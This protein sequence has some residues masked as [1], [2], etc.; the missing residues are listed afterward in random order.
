M[1][2][3]RSEPTVRDFDRDHIILHSG[4]N[5]ENY[6]RTSSQIAKEIINLALSLKS[7]KKKI[8]ISLLAPKSDK[9]N[10]KANKAKRI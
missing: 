1:H 6:D 2:A 3:R 4:T 8:S 10:N 5:D 9:L 7:D